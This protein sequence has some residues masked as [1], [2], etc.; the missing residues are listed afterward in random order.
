METIPTRLPGL[1]LLQPQVFGDHRGFFAE[2]FRADAWAAAGVDVAFVQD[3]HSRSR[4]G[5]LRGMH[6]QTSPGQAK[7]IRCSRGAIVDVV[8]DLRRA[9]PTFGQ[10]E[11]FTLDDETMR[12]LFV[13][14][15]FAHGFCVTSEVADVAYKCSNYYDAA[16]ESGIAYDDPEVGIV[17]PDDVEP[18]VSERDA[19]APRLSEI[20][21][22][23][24]F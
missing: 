13:P 20:A 10:W 19:E 24:P 9:S 17:W 11:A 23:L 12:Q 14:V 15:G 3:N 5:T 22:S 7:L 18:V 4:R 6:F 1:V 21:G 16:T 8:V 2:T